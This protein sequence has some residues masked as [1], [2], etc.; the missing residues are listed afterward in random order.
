MVYALKP[1]KV[2]F[3]IVTF[4]YVITIK[5]T[6]STITSCFPCSFTSTV[7]IYVTVKR[8][9]LIHFNFICNKF[10]DSNI[11]HF[12]AVFYKITPKVPSLTAEKL[13]H[14]RSQLHRRRKPTRMQHKP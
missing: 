11:Q 4:N 1:M 6:T 2:V 9:T 13:F 5:A 8:F 10:E 12:V 7:R 3:Y 14:R